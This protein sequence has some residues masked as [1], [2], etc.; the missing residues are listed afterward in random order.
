M[1][2]VTTKEYIKQRMQVKTQ[3]EKEVADAKALFDA[4]DKPN[5]FTSENDYDSYHAYEKYK[6]AKANLND[7]R[8]HV[9]M[10][11]AATI[12]CIYFGYLWK[13]GKGMLSSWRR[14]YFEL[15]SNAILS[16]YTDDTKTKLKGKIVLI[17]VKSAV[18]LS[19]PA[20]KKTQ[21]DEHTPYALYLYTRGR[22]YQ[23]EYGG[24]DT[25]SKYFKA[26]QEQC[27]C[28]YR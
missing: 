28:N 16:Y 7:S 17:N 23:L 12:E 13:K 22:T 18:M 4:V 5:I 20:R 6:Q 8:L 24:Q 21:T 2:S 9:P 11:E 15:S 27:I 19:K 26:T 14:R 25:D 3:L 10:P 1:A